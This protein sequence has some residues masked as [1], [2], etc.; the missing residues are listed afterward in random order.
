MPE[1]LSEKVAEGLVVNRRWLQDKGI[2]RPD[3]DYYLR[4]GALKPVARGFYRRPGP[5]LPWQ[6]I[7]YSL[8]Q[9]GFNCHVGGHSALD[10]QGYAHFLPLSGNREVALYSAG[11]LPQW[12]STDN[13][14]RPGDDKR[15]TRW[16]AE[17]QSGL[18]PVRTRSRSCDTGARFSRRAMTSVRPGRRFEPTDITDRRNRIAAKPARFLWSC[19]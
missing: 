12:L 2:A 16:S 14:D 9:M 17:T 5:P 6:S 8:Q 18:H 7:A 15:G 1:S 13:A 4:S 19:L 10:D 3:V 11:P